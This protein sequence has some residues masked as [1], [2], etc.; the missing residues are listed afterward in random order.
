[1]QFFIPFRQQP[2]FSGYLIFGNHY[3]YSIHLN[4]KTIY[5]TDIYPAVSVDCS[6]QL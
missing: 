6:F 4:K 3:H 1:M 5:E 2:A